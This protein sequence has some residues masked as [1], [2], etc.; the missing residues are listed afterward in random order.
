M[1]RD[2][3]REDEYL[4]LYRP[5]SGTAHGSKAQEHISV[6]AGGLV[7]VEPIRSPV[8]FRPVF[9]L[10]LGVAFR[11][12]HVMVLECRPGE[13]DNYNRTY[14]ERWRSPYFNVPEVTVVEEE[15]PRS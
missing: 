8:K 10:A 7:R 4:G 5:L 11:T 3:G 1:A 6:F 13:I 14:K 2:L 15:S 9:G 12:Y